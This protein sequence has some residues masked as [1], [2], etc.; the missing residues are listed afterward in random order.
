MRFWLAVQ[1]QYCTKSFFLDR[2]Y[3]IPA[4][5]SSS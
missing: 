3:N 2:P 1:V 5:A 4:R